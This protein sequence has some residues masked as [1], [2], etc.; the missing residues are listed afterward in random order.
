VLIA[1]VGPR[2]ALFAVGAFLPVLAALTWRRLARIDEGAV[3]P[4][5]HVL[6]LRGIPFLAPLPLQSLEFLASRLTP[7]TLAQGETLFSRDEVGD[8][9]YIL[10]DGSLEIDLTDETKVEH[11]P[12]FVGEI[13]LLRDIP[14]TATVRAGTDAS[15]WALER[16]DFLDTVSSHARSR[17]SA[18]EVA[19][20]RL[21]VVPVG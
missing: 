9:F 17:A 16:S 10:R 11:A 20:G 2:G 15:L 19:S 4:E 3:V 6:A 5:D 7:M 21:G 1:A 18:N 14:R 8:R 13:A 12:S